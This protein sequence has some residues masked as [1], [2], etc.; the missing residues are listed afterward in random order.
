MSKNC[1]YLWPSSPPM[2]TYVIYGWSLGKMVDRK[3]DA[4]VTYLSFFINYIFFLFFTDKAMS[5]LGVQINRQFHQHTAV[6]EI[7]T[8][9]CNVS[10]FLFVI[11]FQWWKL[12]QT[13]SFLIKSVKVTKQ[14][15]LFSD[16]FIYHPKVLETIVTI[17]CCN[18]ELS[19]KMS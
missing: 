14:I 9:D 15:K 7:V 18:D 10:V 12:W 5:C 6:E 2:N 11:I 1:P 17:I 19:S 16:F 8:Y 4:K 3:F 13:P